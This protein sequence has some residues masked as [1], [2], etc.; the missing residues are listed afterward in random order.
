MP[1]RNEHYKFLQSKYAADIY[2]L[3]VNKVTYTGISKN[4]GASPN[5]TSNTEQI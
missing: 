4:K 1:Y 2:L 3:K 5:F